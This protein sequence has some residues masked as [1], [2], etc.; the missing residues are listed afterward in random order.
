[1]RGIITRS[2]GVIT[3]LEGGNYQVGT[4]YYLFGAGSYPVS[5]RLFGGIEQKKSRTTAALSVY[6]EVVLLLAILDGRLSSSKACDWH[7]EW[8]A[9]NVVKPCEVAEFN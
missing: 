7:T 5:S 4:A 8:R 9:R 1:L 3:P 6:V 2:E